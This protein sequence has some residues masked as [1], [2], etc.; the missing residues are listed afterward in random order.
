MAPLPATN[1]INLFGCEI[2]VADMMQAVRRVQDWIVGGEDRCHIVVTPNVDHVVMLQANKQ[3]QEVYKTADMVL[4]DGW[5]VVAASR[6][7]RK[8]LPERVPGSDLVPCLFKHT[9][10][11]GPLSVYLLGAAAGVADRAAMN[12]AD[13]WPSVTVV[14]TY[15]PPLGFEHDA[16]ENEAILARIAAAHPD[17][18]VVG[19]GAPKQ[20]LW[21]HG[22]RDRIQARVALC[23]GATIDF[24]AGEKNRA[25][26]WVRGVG[27]EW[28][29]RMLGE[30]RLVKRYIRDAW[31]F[32]QLLW[33]EW[34]FRG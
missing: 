24:L 9:K 18:L 27:C 17:V 12:I 28:L 3:L 31:I 16:A 20:E 10:T 4:A 33:R 11:H 19:L 25:P 15:S 29:F 26:R 34:S 6:L 22:H 2:D 30:R 7:L 14:G 5:P 13:R 1:R 32:P 21:V 8:P 23:V